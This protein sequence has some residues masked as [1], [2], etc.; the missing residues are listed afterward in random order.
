MHKNSSICGKKRDGILMILKVFNRMR[1]VIN[2]CQ[3]MALFSFTFFR[4]KLFLL[5]R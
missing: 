3:K 1:K 2:N 5:T 4:V